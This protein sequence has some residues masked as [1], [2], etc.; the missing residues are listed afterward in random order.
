MVSFLKSTAGG[1]L[2]LFAGI[3]FFLVWLS[4]PITQWIGIGEK[5]QDPPLFIG[6]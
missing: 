4:V 5:K 2:L 6:S 3:V 1:M